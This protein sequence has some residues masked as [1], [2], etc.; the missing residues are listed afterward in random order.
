MQNFIIQPN[1]FLKPEIQAFYHSNYSGGA[2]QWRI[3]GTVENIICTLKNDITSFSEIALQ[4]AVQYLS[5][6]LSTDLPEILHVAKLNSLT[7]C[8]VPRAKTNYQ[9]NQLLFKTTVS[10]V[11]NR[12][13]GF[14]DG[15]GYIIRHTDTRTTH[16]DRAGYGGNGDLPYPEITKKTCNISNEVRGKN[17]LLIDDLYTETINI[18][19]DAIQALLDN[20]AQSVIFYAVGKNLHG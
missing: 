7:V 18:D 2:G 1:Q 10:D 16:R 13:D 19:E 5:N 12:L 8:T 3:E 14:I 4:G 20:G 9:P 17:I 15:T 6:I 11:V